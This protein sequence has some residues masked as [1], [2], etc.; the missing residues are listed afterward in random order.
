MQV[1]AFISAT[2]LQLNV[3]FEIISRSNIQK[4]EMD[5]TDPHPLSL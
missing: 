3:N 1:E 5:L 4:R 2:L